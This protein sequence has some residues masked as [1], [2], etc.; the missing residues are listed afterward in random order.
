MFGKM[1]INLEAKE[2]LAVH[3]KA[4][5]KV[6]GKHFVYVKVK[7][8]FKETEVNIGREAGEFIEVLNGLKPNQKIV[9]EGSFWLRSKLHHV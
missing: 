2:V 4:I 8:G 3:K 9:T 5:Q 7:N 6:D 1:Y